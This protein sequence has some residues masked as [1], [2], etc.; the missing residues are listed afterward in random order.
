MTIPTITTPRLTLRAF[1]AE[2][3]ATLTRILAQEGILKYFPD[4][5]PPTIER[6]KRFITRQLEEWKAHGYAWWAVEDR[7]TGALLGWNGLRYLPDTDETEVGYLLQK[8]FWGRGLATEGAAEAVRFGF[9]HIV[10][11]EVIA[12]AHPENVASRRVMEKIGMRF[13]RVTEYFDM[14]VARYVLR[15]E[16]IERKAG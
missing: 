2:D 14:H 1:R 13:D 15:R 8:G 11:D 16:D 3:A 5:S 9:E 12:L 6:S 10:L 4:D 7:I